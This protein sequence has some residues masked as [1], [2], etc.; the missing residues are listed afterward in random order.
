MID[1]KLIDKINEL[2]DYQDTGLDENVDSYYAR[3][4]VLNDL[5]YTVLN[6]D[7]MTS[8]KRIIITDM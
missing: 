2:F 3:E 5:L 7:K 1:Q 4:F 8:D 6:I